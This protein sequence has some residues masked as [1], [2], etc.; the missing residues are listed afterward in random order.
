MRVL[1]LCDQRG[2]LQPHTTGMNTRH[3]AISSNEVCAMCV[4]NH[5]LSVRLPLVVPM[6]HV[7]RPR[8]AWRLITN[9]DIANGCVYL[10]K[11]VKVTVVL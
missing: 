3:G 11:W 4:L 9:C 2:C 7:K 10:S 5:C 1:G 8:I 6:F